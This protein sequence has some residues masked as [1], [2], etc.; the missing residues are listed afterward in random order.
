MGEGTLLDRLM[1][2]DRDRLAGQSI[3]I[4]RDGLRRDLE[5]LLN[6]RRRFLSWRDDLEELDASLL[7]Y[8]LTDFTNAPI[9]AESFRTAF[10]AEVEALIRRLEPRISNFEV[11]IVENKEITDRILRFRIVGMVDLSGE[12]RQITFDSHVDPVR[13]GVVVKE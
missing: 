2:G 10:V 11:V 5:G 6:T 7:S 12:R 4:L 3:A 8:G 1:E 9:T 13:C